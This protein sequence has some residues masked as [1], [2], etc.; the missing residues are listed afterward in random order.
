MQRRT[1]ISA[2]AALGSTG[3]IPS[4]HAQNWQ[5]QGPIRIIVPIAAGGLTDAM[6]RTL[7]DELKGS[8]NTPVIVDNRPGG[9]FGIGYQ[10]LKTAK[11]DGLTIAFVF[12]SAMTSMQL[13]YKNLPYKPSDFQPI[14]TLSK[15]H[16]VL[17]V[18]KSSPYNTLAEYVE[19]VKKQ[20]SPALVAVS[21][22]GGSPHLM[23]E[24]LGIVAGFSI[25]SVVYRGETPAVL[26]LVGGQIPAFSGAYGS[27]AEFVRNGTVKVLA[28]SSDKRV[29]DAPDIPTFKE[30]GYPSILVDFWFGLAATAGTPQ[31]IIESLRAAISKAARSPAFTARLKAQPDTHLSLS[32]PDEY[33]RLVVRETEM[34]RKLI[35]SRKITVES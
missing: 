34:W 28:I 24:E 10:A 13:L 3:L 31:D 27:V 16:H 12:A 15:I 1:I 14:T 35:V 30:Q 21:A 32:T 9:N 7:A 20:K 29:S 2:L 25:Q 11:P 4:V 6:A 19:A 33:N 22:V 18:P 5:P 23:M 17:A 8:L 26:E